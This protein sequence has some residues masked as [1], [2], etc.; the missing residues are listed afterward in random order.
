MSQLSEL[1]ILS[2]IRAVMVARKDAKKTEKRAIFLETLCVFA[3]LR[4]TL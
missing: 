4:E 2:Y 3:P 1:D